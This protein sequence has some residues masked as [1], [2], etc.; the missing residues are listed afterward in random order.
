MNAALS[1]TALHVALLISLPPLLPGVIGKTK[2]W[3][4]GRQG[5]PLLQTY[6]DV[7]KCWRKAAVYSASTTWI[8]RAGPIVSLA[9]AVTAGL[10]VPLAGP[11]APLSF[12]GDVI[13]FAYLLGLGRFAIAAAA[14]DTGSSF[15]G[16]GASR[17]VAFAALAE[18]VLFLVLAVLALESGELSFSA[19][20]QTLAHAPRS[21]YTAALPLA[22]LALF[23][24][25]LTE[26]SRVP[27]DDPATHLELTMI[28]EVM[29]LDHGGPDLGIVYYASAIKLF[30]LSTVAVHVLVPA[31]SLP[32]VSSAAAVALGTIAIAVLI[33]IVESTMARL[34]LPR[35]PQ[36]IIA[37]AVLA[38]TSLTIVLSGGS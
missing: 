27:V 30:V 38:A 28:H 4:A 22:A 3:F 13:L 11:Y 23:A 31:G 10:L 29:V 32:P 5:P 14:L 6:R 35:V 19:A 36:F 16:M 8:F 2:A 9:T 34:R 37:A 17:E 15:E 7:L 25:I 1:A 26:N 24:V 21:G 20:F 18:P 12:A 33:G